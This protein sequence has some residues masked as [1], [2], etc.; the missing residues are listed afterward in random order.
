MSRDE[1]VSTRADMAEAQEAARQFAAI[2]AATSQYKAFALARQQ[3]QH[4]AEAQRAIQDFQRQQH[5]V[6]MTQI[7]GTVTEADVQELRRLHE[8]LMRIPTVQE[9]VHGQEELARTCQAVAH[10][11]SEIIGTDFV[12]HRSGC[13]G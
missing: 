4:D 5:Y 8:A 11:I 7:W 13:C 12:P 1:G 2:L 6:Q 3:L 9:Y 10:I